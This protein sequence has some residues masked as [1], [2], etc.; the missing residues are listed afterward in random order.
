MEIGHYERRQVPTQTLGYPRI[1]RDRE[2]KRALE[3]Y[4]RG[5]ADASSLMRVFWEVAEDG[6]RAQMAAEIDLVGVGGETLYD[7]VLDWAIR[8]D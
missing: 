8:F 7:H 1:G 4:W 5:D 2:L 3:S 6:W